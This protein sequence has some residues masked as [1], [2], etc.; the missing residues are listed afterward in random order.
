MFAGEANGSQPA[1]ENAPVHA[2][3]PA[4]EVAPEPGPAAAEPLPEGLADLP[5]GAG[6]AAALATIDRSRLS[7]ADVYELLAARAR[8]IAYEQG[9]LLA[10]LLEAA[11]TGPGFGGDGKDPTAR[12]GR[13]D[14]FCADESA[15]T[16]CWSRSYAQ[17]QTMLAH[18]LIERLPVVYA[19]LVAGRIDACRAAVFSDALALLDDDV[20]RAIAAKLIGDAERLTPSE[21]RGRLRY[22]V[23]KADPSR[24]RRRYLR[25]VAD[26]QVWTR[27]GE[28]GTASLYGSHLPPD[29]AAAAEERITAL[30]RA[31]R[32]AGDE[33][34]LAQLRADAY[35]DLLIGVPF[36]LQPSTDPL[37][38]TADAETGEEDRSAGFTR[39]EQADLYPTLTSEQANARWNPIASTSTS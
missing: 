24:A 35:L 9:Q 6:L 32:A 18:D 30:A 13:L 4:P 11:R 29:R 23:G 16:L 15:F 31:A 33:R 1:Q 26:R 7:V 20:A 27:L 19:A 38:R 10:D 22:R 5:A 17:G 34:T 2:P 8:L 28:D 25:G 36:R 37:T 14:E 3:E 39:T 21:L 12:P